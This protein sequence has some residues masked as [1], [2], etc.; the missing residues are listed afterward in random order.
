M[1]KP[2]RRQ[3]E[4][5]ADH[6]SELPDDILVAILS[7]CCYED[8]VRIASVSRRWERLVAQLPNLTL[9]LSVLGRLTSI[10]TP[11]ERR[12]QSIARTLR[13]RCRDG[14]HAVV[15]RLELAYRKD[16]PMECRYADEFIALANA[17]KLVLHLQCP[18]LAAHDADPGDE[19]AGAWSLQLPPATTELEL[20]PHRY[21]VRPPHIHGSS[22]STLRSLALVGTTVLRQDFLL[23][24]LPSLEHLRIADCT[25]PAS[26]DITSGAMPRLKHL[27]ITDVSV[28]TDG[29]RAAI[30][31]LAD[32]LRTLRMSCHLCSETEAPS[33]PEFFRPRSRFRASFTAYSSFRLRAP[34]LQIFDW[35]C[36]YADDVRVESV[37]RLTDVA[38]EIAAGRVKRQFCAESRY[39]TTQQRDKLM[40]DILQELMPG[41]RPRSWTNVKRKCIQHDRWLCFEITKVNA[42]RKQSGASRSRCAADG[43]AASRVR[44]RVPWRRALPRPAV[45]VS[46]RKETEKERRAPRVS[47]RVISRTIS[48]RVDRCAVTRAEP[49]V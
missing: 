5:T 11:S 42:L 37:G 21:A 36:C 47:G 32:E 25:L 2:P 27:D 49:R 17:A 28:M 40:I 26:I 10:G 24:F 3:T 29:T 20:V 12:V 46:Q 35:R 43:R 33:E 38:V 14:S 45:A 8:A 7:L 34:R 23:T 31:V 44:G 1:E 41:L 30:N 4:E 22:V 9:C 6:I 18:M 13:R 19:D 39:V 15:E 48:R 16:V